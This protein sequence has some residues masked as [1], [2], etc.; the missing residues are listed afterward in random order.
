LEQEAARQA[1][2]QNLSHCSEC[3]LNENLWLC[4]TCGNLGCGRAQ[5]G[6]VGGNSHGLAHTQAT[7]HPVAVK[8][9]SLTADGTADIYCYSCDEERI[10]PELPDHL[11]HWGINIKD[12]IKT[13]KSL[14]EM[15]VEQNLLW[16]FSMTTEDGKEL[17]PLFGAG[18]TGLK[19]LGTWTLG[20]STK[21]VLTYFFASRKQLLPCQY[22]SESLLFSRIC[23][24]LLPA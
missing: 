6:G 5:F 12:R 23:G 3:D 15:Q 19:N 7:S 20:T 8:L 2:S 10:D 24:S 9:G 17:K 14:T 13:E 16:E 11:A 1:G 4:L 22:A 18:F 21:P